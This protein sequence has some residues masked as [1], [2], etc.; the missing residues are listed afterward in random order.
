MLGNLLKS[1][2]FSLVL[3]DKLLSELPRYNSSQA[4]EDMMSFGWES[5]FVTI[6]S[7][8]LAQSHVRDPSCHVMYFSAIQQF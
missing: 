4:M 2:P 1:Q 6:T 7:G 5:S 8:H 3:M